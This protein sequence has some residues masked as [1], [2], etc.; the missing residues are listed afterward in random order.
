MSRG[1]TSLLVDDDY[2]KRKARRKQQQSEFESIWDEAYERHI[3]RLSPEELRDI[4]SWTHTHPGMD[5]G[6]SW[7]PT[8]DEFNEI[9]YERRAR[10][11]RLGRVGEKLRDVFSR[12]NPNLLR[13][14][15]PSALLAGAGKALSPFADA[16]LDASLTAEEA[17]PQRGSQPR[18][19]YMS[20]QEMDL[21]D[22][23]L[24]S[25]VDIYG[26][27]PS[28]WD[29]GLDPVLRELRS[30]TPL[31]RPMSRRDWERRRTSEAFN[32]QFSGR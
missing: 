23:D 17:N 31:E 2:L 4:D 20:Q 26:R 19:T 28:Y 16:L 24:Q 10:K 14:L 1:L 12:V 27:D 3:S 15:G 11:T 21:E 18:H 30:S 25:Y 6:S 29:A 32:R 9:E 7:S 22:L 5:Y 8:D 13:G